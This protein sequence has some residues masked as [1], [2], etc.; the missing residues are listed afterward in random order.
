M[1][2]SSRKHS[3]TRI[4]QEADLPHRETSQ[5]FYPNVNLPVTPCI[6]ALTLSESSNM[7]YDTKTREYTKYAKSTIQ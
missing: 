5:T 3:G 6:C 4:C 7:E 2:I 1:Y